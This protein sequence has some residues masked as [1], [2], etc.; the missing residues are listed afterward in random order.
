MSHGTVAPRIMNL[1]GGTLGRQV[2]H[3]IFRRMTEN[4]AATDDPNCEAFSGILIA[5]Q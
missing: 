5:L 3:D 2:C 4:K 1:Q